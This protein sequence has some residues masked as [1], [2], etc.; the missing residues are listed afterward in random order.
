MNFLR[1]VRL[2][3]R[4]VLFENSPA[5]ESIGFRFGGGFFVF[6]FHEIGGERGNLIFT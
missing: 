2:F 6:G 5:H 1:S 4:F 3:F